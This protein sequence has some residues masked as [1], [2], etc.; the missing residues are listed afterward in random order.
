[1]DI[2]YRFARPAD[3][4]AIVEF[5]DYW[6]AGKARS[7]GVK[8]ATHDYFVPAVRLADYLRKYYV[9]LAWAGDE[10]VGWAVQSRRGVMFHLLIAVPYR[11]RG[12]GA[13]MVR[14]L[15]PLKIRSKLDM[16]S[17]DPTGFYE[18]QGFVDAELPLQGTKKN[19]RVLVRGADFG[20]E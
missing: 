19:I 6:L 12:I 9:L 7:A 18:G 20:R 17:G 10:L 1:M 5:V 15:A 11:G 14:I 4:P 16:K 13:R 8:G 2:A 3:V